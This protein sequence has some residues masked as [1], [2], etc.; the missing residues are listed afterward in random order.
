[1][2]SLIPYCIYKESYIVVDMSELNDFNNSRDKALKRG[3]RER[4]RETQRQRPRV[5]LY[6]VA[7]N[8]NYSI[9]KRL[10]QCISVSLRTILYIL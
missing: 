10:M 5:P 8:F 7:Y 3:E 4:S 9:Y 2:F 6:V 1:M